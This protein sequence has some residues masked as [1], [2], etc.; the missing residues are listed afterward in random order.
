MQ[1]YED[2]RRKFA[3]AGPQGARGPRKHGGPNSNSFKRRSLKL[4]KKKDADS[5]CE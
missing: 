1:Y 4:T 3:G 5:D 2:D